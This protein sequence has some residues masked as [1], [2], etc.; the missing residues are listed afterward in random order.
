MMSLKQRTPCFAARDVPQLREKGVV[1]FV[2]VLIGRFRP[3][4]YTFSRLP[5]FFS[6]CSGCQHLSFPKRAGI[7][8]SEPELEIR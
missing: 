1:N 2:W 8:Q 3:F 6:F 7:A 5:S 4:L